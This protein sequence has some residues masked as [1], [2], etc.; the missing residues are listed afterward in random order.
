MCLFLIGLLFWMFNF[1]VSYSCFM[2]EISSLLSLRGYLLLLKFLLLPVLSL[3]PLNSLFSVCLLSLF[4]FYN[5]FY[6]NIW[7]CTHIKE[8]GTKVVTCSWVRNGG[9]ERSWFFFIWESFCVSFPLD[10]S[11]SQKESYHLRLRGW[12]QKRGHMPL[13]GSPLYRLTIP[14]SPVC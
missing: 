4:S 10:C 6:S 7:T 3:L 1:I 13:V 11:S 14:V 8:W 9:K 2:D 12:D 5:R